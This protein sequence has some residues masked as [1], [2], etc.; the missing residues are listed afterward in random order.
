MRKISKRILAKEARIQSRAAAV[1]QQ[2]HPIAPEAIKTLE[3][4]LQGTLVLPTDPDYNNQRQEWNPAFQEFPQIIAYC[5]VFSDVKACLR[6]AYQNRLWVVARSGRH[7]TAGYS[8]NNSMVIDVSRI[9]YT[10][11]DP[12]GKRAF[13]GAGT[14]FSHLNAVLNDYRFHVPGGAC[15]DVCVAGYMQGGGYGFTSRLYGMNCDNVTE[16]TVMLWDGSMIVANQ[17]KNADLFWAIR[18]GTGNNFGILLQLTYRLHDLYRVWGFHVQ[19]PLERAA[20]GLAEL[21][22]NFMKTG[23]PPELGYYAF[24]AYQGDRPVL[25]VSG[26]YAG[27]PDDGEKLLEPLLQTGG[28]LVSQKTGSYAEINGWLYDDKYDIPVVPDNAREDKQCGFIARLLTEADWQKIIDYF[29][30]TPNNYG[31]IALEPFGGAINAY[32]V[33]KAG[34]AFIHRDVY[35]D[36]YVD[37]FWLSEAERQ[38]VVV[39][40]DG[41]M[42]LMKPYFN[43]H[44]YQNYPRRSQV[45]YRWLYWGNYFNSLLFVKNKYDPENFFHYQ[46]S[47]APIPDD[48]PPEIRRDDSDPL[49]DD[50]TIHYEPYSR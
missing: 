36:F 30:T 47:I 16:V 39:W 18:G 22:R 48:A 7:S 26:L 33:G 12:I 21:Q 37:V 8:V 19:W 10:V 14:P 25:L 13:V 15:Q 31:A 35:M 44:A 29:K 11:V 40:L 20:A 32:P 43:G 28:V 5:E 2:F 50:P 49:F 4:Q 38:R 46:Q 45:N 34:N 41:F 23:A 3:Q 6:F 17:S 9:R 27:G 24:V 1:V 42:E